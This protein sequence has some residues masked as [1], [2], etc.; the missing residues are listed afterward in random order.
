MDK[1]R[2]RCYNYNR[3]ILQSSSVP[4]GEFKMSRLYLV[5]SDSH[6]NFF[7]V[8]EA[9]ARQVK[10]P[11]GIF[12]LGD[13]IGDVKFFDKGSIPI[14]C[15]SGNCDRRESFA[16]DEAPEENLVKICGYTVMMT[17]GHRYGVKS[18]LGNIISAAKERD[19]DILLFGHTHERLEATYMKDNGKPLYIL[20]P[21]S[22]GGYNASFGVIS[23]SDGGE[24]LFSHGEI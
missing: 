16:D 14:Y 9:L 3:K 22:I 18:G 17:H 20:N 7:K 23:I 19:A 21:G 2:Q 10:R 1:K 5:F 8:N 6:G 24:I 12:F 11:D 13:G 4:N 15:V